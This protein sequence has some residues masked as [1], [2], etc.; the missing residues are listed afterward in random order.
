MVLIYSA[1]TLITSGNLSISFNN[2][3]DVSSVTKDGSIS[4]TSVI[5][6]FLNTLAARAYVY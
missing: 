6:V 3:T 2:A 5:P 1:A 4:P